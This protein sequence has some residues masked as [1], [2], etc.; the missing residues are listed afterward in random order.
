VHYKRD[1]KIYNL[2]KYTTPGAMAFK[3]EKISHE[4]MKVLKANEVTFS[5][6]VLSY[7]HLYPYVH[8]SG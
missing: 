4:P 1:L 2:Q 8:I 7:C 5:V 3:S 6:I